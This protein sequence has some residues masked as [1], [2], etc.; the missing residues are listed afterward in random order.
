[1]FLPYFEYLAPDELHQPS[2]I[3]VLKL[4]APLILASFSLNVAHTFLPSLTQMIATVCNTLDSPVS[5]VNMF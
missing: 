3:L 4:L 1:M 2:N 5:K